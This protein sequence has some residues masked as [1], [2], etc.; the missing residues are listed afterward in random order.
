MSSGLQCVIARI[1][2]IMDELLTHQCFHSREYPSTVVLGSHPPQPT[3]Q[4]RQ[5]SPLYWHP[6]PYIDICK[7]SFQSLGRI[8]AYEPD[9][10]QL[11][12]CVRETYI[13]EQRLA[14]MRLHSV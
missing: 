5:K 9:P 12:E 3:E 11:A 6:W 4:G 10:Q 13:V 7:K 2:L 1:I 14:T 8:P